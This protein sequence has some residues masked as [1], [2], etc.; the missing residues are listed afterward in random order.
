[1]VDGHKADVT[2]VAF[3]RDGGRL[4]SGSDDRTVR[5]WDAETGKPMGEPFQGHTGWVLFVA[6]SPDGKRVVS[7]SADQTVRIWA[8]LM[9]GA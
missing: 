2:S 7:G 6:F 9:A 1:V 4:V 3:S 8:L 5:I